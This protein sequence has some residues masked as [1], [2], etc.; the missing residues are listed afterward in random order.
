MGSDITSVAF[1][2]CSRRFPDRQTDLRS[3]DVTAWKDM[4]MVYLPNV[5]NPTTMN[6]HRGIVLLSVMQNG[7][8]DA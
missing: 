6:E 1:A 2:Q 7:T 4:L 8:W 5:V 3:D